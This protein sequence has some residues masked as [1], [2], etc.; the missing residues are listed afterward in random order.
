MPTGGRSKADQEEI[1]RLQKELEKADN[2]NSDK[3]D[4]VLPPAGSSNSPKNVGGSVLGMSPD[5]YNTNKASRLPNMVDY[6]GVNND[7]IKKPLSAKAIEEFGQETV[8]AYNDPQ[9]QIAMQAKKDGRDSPFIRS[10]LKELASNKKLLKLVEFMDNNG[11]YS[12]PT[13]ND[14][15]R[16]RN[17]GSSG[18][19]VGTRDARLV[20]PGAKIILDNIVNANT[21]LKNSTIDIQGRIDS[22]KEYLN[23]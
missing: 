4:D 23:R 8:D 17:S 19:S 1:T 3:V 7:S 13:I 21:R 12:V 6:L 20:T 22:I 11:Q 2:D 10:K 5:E 9:M 14:I 16:L 15:D 18:V